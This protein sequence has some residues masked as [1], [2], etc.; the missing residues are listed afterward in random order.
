MIVDVRPISV[1]DTF[2]LHLTEPPEIDE[3]EDWTGAEIA[4]YGPQAADEQTTINGTA[5]IANGYV[6]GIV[7]GTADASQGIWNWRMG[8]TSDNYRSTVAS[9]I[10]E[11]RDPA[12]TTNITYEERLVSI[13]ESV[14]ENKLT[15]RGDV[16]QYTIGDRTIGLESLRSL[17]KE[18]G[19]A[20][21][22]LRFR[23][24]RQ[25][26]TVVRGGLFHG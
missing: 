19:H 1:G 10:V 16:I 6:T 17:R 7:S 13:L 5:E 25:E 9:G 18:L 3:N 23:Q 15:E 14:I 26:R 11:I 4:L 22:A 21:L 12:V 20:K 24:G 8:V 2:R